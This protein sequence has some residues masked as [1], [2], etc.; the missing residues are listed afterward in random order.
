MKKANVAS[1]GLRHFEYSSSTTERILKKLDRRQELNIL[2]HVC[3]FR[4]IC[5]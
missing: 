1:D 2:Y 3:I 4:P 5:N